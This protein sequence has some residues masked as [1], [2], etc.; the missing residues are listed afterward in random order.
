MI[1]MKGAKPTPETMAGKAI[2]ERAT[3]LEQETS[4]YTRQAEVYARL[5]A[6]WTQ[7]KTAED[8]GID[9]VTV[10]RHVDAIKTKLRQAEAT[11]EEI[12]PEVFQ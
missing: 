7:A 12:D 1:I 11:I 10:S 5:E 6:G 9:P 8:I 4:L 3:K 2:E